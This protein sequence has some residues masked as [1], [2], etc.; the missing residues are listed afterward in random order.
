MP[1]VFLRRT[2]PGYF[3]SHFY[4]CDLLLSILRIERLT[5]GTGSTQHGPV[6]GKVDG[7]LFR[8]LPVGD[9]GFTRLVKNLQDTRGGNVDERHVDQPF[10]VG[11]NQMLSSSSDRTWHLEIESFGRVSHI[12]TNSK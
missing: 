2:I 10:L 9:L 7:L 1:A 6:L 12:H 11:V 8:F 3:V 4:P 5:L